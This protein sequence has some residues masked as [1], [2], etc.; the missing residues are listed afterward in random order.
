MRNSGTDERVKY[1]THV[2]RWEQML[3]RARA[4]RGESVSP[5]LASSLLKLD[6]ER[7]PGSG[8]EP[9]QPT[10]PPELDAAASAPPL[11]PPATA[12]GA[13]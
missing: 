7:R 4:E 2:D 12:H 10:A 6:A 13:R 1:Q 8:Q 11:P 5:Q 3:E 9:S